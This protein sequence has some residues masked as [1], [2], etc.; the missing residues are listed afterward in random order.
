MKGNERKDNKKKSSI[1]NGEGGC[2]RYCGYE[3][4]RVV[5]S[6]MLPSMQ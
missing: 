5:R 3:I 2:Q 4:W 6:L 1:W